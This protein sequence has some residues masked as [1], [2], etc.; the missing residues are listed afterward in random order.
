MAN[1]E[2]RLAI[3]IDSKEAEQNIKRLRTALK[4]IGKETVEAG[5]GLELLTEAMEPL[6]KYDSVFT[7]ASGAAK[8]LAKSTKDMSKEVLAA[9]KG[10][11][12]LNDDTKKSTDSSNKLQT[13]VDNTAKEVREFGAITDVAGVAVWGM[14]GK[15]EESA[16]DVDK[17]GDKAKDAKSGLKGLGD[18][19]EKSKSKLEKLKD[20]VNNFNESMSGLRNAALVGMGALTGVLYKSVDAAQGFETAMAE[21]NKTVDFAAPDGLGKMRSELEEL[22]TVIPLPFEELAAVTAAGGQLGIAEKDLVR[23]TEVMAKMGVAFDMP[24]EQAADAMAKIANVFSI[25]IAEIDKLGDAINTLSNSTPA[26][27]SEIINALQRVGGVA[28][29]YGLTEDA[30]AGLVGAFIAMGRPAEVAASAVNGMLTTFSTLDNASKTQRVGFKK[31]GLDIDE[32]AQLVATKP[33][34]AIETYLEAVNKLPQSERV[35]TNAMIIG[36]DFGDDI[37]ML[38]GSVEVLTNNW[39]MLGETAGSTKDYMGSMQK[40]FEAMSGTSAAQMQIL[41][42]SIDNLF[43]AVG[44]ALLPAFNKIVEAIKPVV[45]EMNNWAKANP[46]LVQQILLVS[47]AIG[48]FILAVSGIGLVAASFIAIAN[49]IGL[50]VLAVSGLIGVGAALVA[51]W[52]AIKAKAT[53]VWSGVVNLVND[54]KVAFAALSAVMTSIVIGFIAVNAQAIAA[55]AVFTTMRIA[56]IAYNAVFA[57]TNGLM[58]AWAGAK[59]VASLAMIGARVVANTAI[60]V[61]HNTALVA[62]KVA[63]LAWQAVLGVGK[64]IAMG[65]AVAANTVRLIAQTTALAAIRVA[66]VAW[67]VASSAAAIGAKA[68]GVAI[69]FMLGPIGIAITVIGALVAAG[70]YLYKNWDEVKDKATAIWNSVKET[71]INSLSGLPAK[72]LQAGKDAVNGLINGIKG[73]IADV[74]NA[75]SELGQAAWGGVKS[76]LQIRSPSRKMAELG[77]NTAEGLAK[78]IKDNKKKPVSE[79]QKMAE[80]AVKAVKDTIA[81]LQRD[82]ALFGN[83]DP[84]AAMLWD[85]ANTDKYKGVGDGLFNQ[86]VDL[87]KQKEALELAEKFKEALKGIQ[88]SINGSVSTELEKWA[89]ALYGGNKEL[90][91]LKANKKSELLGE[92]ANLDFSNLSKE[93]AKGNLEIDR[94]IELMGARTDLDKELLKISYE[95]NDLLEKYNYYLETGQIA[96]YNE[97]KALVDANAERE[98]GLAL[99]K[100]QQSAGDAFYNMTDSMQA[101]SPMGKLIAERDKRLEI[102]EEAR[103]LE[104]ISAQ[105]HA[106]TLLA[107]DQAYMDGKRDL[108]LTQSQDLFSGLSGLAKSFAGEQSGIYRA[109]FAIEKGFAIAQAAIAIQQSVAKAMAVGFPANIPLIGQAIAQG[110]Q[111]M[112]SIKSVAMPIGQAHDGI[113]SVPKSGTWNLEKGE[114]VLPAHTAK[115]M[116][117]KLEQGGKVIIHNYSGEKAEAKQDMDGNTIITIGKMVNGIV[118]HK[119]AKFKRQE[120]R[121]GGLFSG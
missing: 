73:K 106:D 56:T 25:P 104:A 57:V 42:S 107:I 110:G 116:D 89:I 71:I 98:K 77:K 95:A 33:K 16:Q 52:D 19:A 121:Q 46:E 24:A 11:S 22:T 108:M 80:Q 86:A 26:K 64:L 43:A 29:V 62:M 14:G 66:T 23:F 41:K 94:Q 8:D 58:A 92:A 60:F 63:T 84:I 90:S 5:S 67:S 112:S 15:A 109:L 13:A 69:R 47:G 18:E 4:N 54:N 38:A 27:A 1:Q 6:K 114:R 53:E 100:A 49:P 10:I 48:G 35:G 120:Q 21:I 101:E 96:R 78:G 87:T 76:F 44:T 20:S 119:L 32:F 85:K 51:N 30:A 97:I 36:K 17:L 70:V 82:I 31:L 12:T 3:V 91:K 118:D 61:V 37:T 79:A 81:T 117:K 55:T 88:D 59:F 72:L 65:A 103:A 93:V 2:S 83:D 34:E 50:V 105:Q 68:L 111:I 102:L 75:A 45:L 99:T 74:K 9:S 28:K 39:E 40:E 113:M 7:K 115:A